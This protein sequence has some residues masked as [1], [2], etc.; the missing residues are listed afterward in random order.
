MPTARSGRYTPCGG[1]SAEWQICHSA[2]TDSWSCFYIANRTGARGDGPPSG[3]PML[4]G[5]G[6]LLLR[7]GGADVCT[8]IGSGSTVGGGRT[9]SVCARPDPTRRAPRQAR[10]SSPALPSGAAGP[11]SYAMCHTFCRRS[12]A[13]NEL[14][15]RPLPASCRKVWATRGRWRP[16]AD[17][18]SVP[19]LRR[20]NYPSAIEEI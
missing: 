6:G 1:A 15:V 7:S 8:A 3:R 16:G 12:V 20:S 19:R 17:L 11:R 5:G 18:G 4:V 14:A 10:C 13:A 9:R 2:D